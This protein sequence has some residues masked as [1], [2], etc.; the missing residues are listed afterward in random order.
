MLAAKALSLTRQDVP[1]VMSGPGHPEMLLDGPLIRILRGIQ[2]LSWKRHK[3]PGLERRGVEEKGLA[4]DTAR[5]LVL[6]VCGLSGS[7]VDS[8]VLLRI[9]PTNPST[10]HLRALL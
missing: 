7:A 10:D 2:G 5:E 4:V 8:L 1:D 6:D 3:H 9:I